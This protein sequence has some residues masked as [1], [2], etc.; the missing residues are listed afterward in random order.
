LGFLYIRC[1]LD[2]DERTWPQPYGTA[3]WCQKETF[4][5]NIEV[6]IRLADR[7]TATCAHGANGNVTLTLAKRIV[8]AAVSSSI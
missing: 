2:G 1:L 7:N 4:W 6:V 8:T 5:S 3:A